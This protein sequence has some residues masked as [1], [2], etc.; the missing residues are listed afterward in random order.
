MVTRAVRKLGIPAYVNERHDICVEQYKVSGSAFKIGS[1]RAY[2]HGTMLIDAAL[3][4]LRGVLRNTKVRAVANSSRQC[5]RR[6]TQTGIQS[7][8]VASVSSPVRNLEEWSA[9]IDHESFVEEVAGA[10]LEDFADG[11]GSL[12]KVSE[13]D[14]LSIEEVRKGSDELQ[15]W[16][17]LHGQTPEFTHDLSHSFAW[18]KLV[19]AF[20]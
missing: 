6:R 7:K 5:L 14:M 10:F 3:H 19:R 4:D 18:G 1:K 15:T 11:T 12:V 13:A 8:G 2:H 17:W 20:L 16:D 9:L